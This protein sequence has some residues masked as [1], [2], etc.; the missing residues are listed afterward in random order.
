M[1]SKMH[2][3]GSGFDRWHRGPAFNVLAD[4][5]D[6]VERKFHLEYDASPELIE[7]DEKSMRRAL[8]SSGNC[9]ADAILAHGVDVD[10]KT[11]EIAD[12]DACFE[13]ARGQC[14]KEMWVAC[15][16]HVHVD[17]DVRRLRNLEL[18]GRGVVERQAS[19]ELVWFVGLI[20]VGTPKSTT[21]SEAPHFEVVGCK[22]LIRS[23]RQSKVLKPRL[24]L[25]RGEVIVGMNGG[26]ASLQHADTTYF[27][28]F[29][30]ILVG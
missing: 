7:V 13:E 1:T 18:L 26:G 14:I 29:E 6:D 2:Q 19:R 3:S 30:Q 15:R 8:S 23:V 27:G 28:H 17:H 16:A 4:A 10:D 9:H 11:H 20:I 25:L 21:P 22:A 12:D 24:V 5:R